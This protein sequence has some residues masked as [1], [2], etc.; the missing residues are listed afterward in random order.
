MRRAF[1]I[2]I[3]QGG[4]SATAEPM[5]TWDPSIGGTA[6]ESSDTT[7]VATT[8]SAGGD[9]HADTS[10]GPLDESEGGTGPKLDVAMSPDIGLPPMGCNQVD[11]LFI[12][13]NSASMNDE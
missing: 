4:C 3:L 7:A 6:G 9:E 13:D 10:T 11:I 12:I 8:E 2:A 5:T 1:F